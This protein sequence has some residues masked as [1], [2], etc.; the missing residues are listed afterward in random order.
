[1]TDVIGVTAKT[2]STDATE[3]STRYTA[4]QDAI[5]HSGTT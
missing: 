3:N 4:F 1:M 5:D 2:K